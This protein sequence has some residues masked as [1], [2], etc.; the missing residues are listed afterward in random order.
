MYKLLF[1]LALCVGSLLTCEAKSSFILKNDLPI[2]R[3]NE[4]FVF[5]RGEFEH[6]FGAGKAGEVPLLVTQGKLINTQTDDLNGDG[7]WDELAFTVDIKAGSS[8]KLYG[9]WI[10]EKKVPK[11]E[12]RT[13]V[14]LGEENKNGG[15]TEVTEADAPVGLAGFPTHYQS[16]G[17][18]WENDK[19]AFRIYF[20]CRNTKDLFG[21]LIPDLIL[22]KAGSPTEPTYHELAPWGM[23]ILHCGSSL[24]AGSLA[25]VEG[26]SLYRLGSTPG[27]HYK[28]I[29]EGPV[30]TIFELTYKGWEVNGN[31]YEATERITLWIGKYWFQS[32]VRIHD[33]IGEKQVATG[34]TTTKLDRDPLQFQANSDYTAILTHGKQSLNNDILA[35]A[36]LAPTKEVRK[37]SRT[38]NT[39]FYKL[40]YQTVPAKSFSQVIS[41]TYYLSQKIKTESP[42][43]H[44]FFAMWGLEN[45]KWNEV[46][47]VKK[48]IREE[49]EKL[50]HPVTIEQGKQENVFKKSV[51]KK[52]METAAMWQ[53]AH[54]NHDL[55]DW[56]NGAFFAGMMAT[57]E[58]TGSKKIYQ[59]MLDMGKANGWKP[60]KLWYH[61]D[62]YAICQTYIDLY[63]LEK[64][65][66]MIQP[67]IDSVN[68]M[69]DTPY[70]ING[71]RKNFWWWCDALF[72]APP[73]LVKLGMTLGDK[74]YLE[75]NDKLFHETVDLLWNKEENLFARDLRFVWGYPEKD[76]KENNG[77]KVFWSRGN[78]WVM[79]GL[80]R[81]LTEL[82]AN[83]PNR[84]FYLDIFK[85]MAK[86]IASLQQADGLWRVSLL[87][88][89]SYPGGEASGSGFY[90]Y[91]LAWG[92]N[93]GILEREIYL[94]VVEKAWTGLNSLLTPEGYVGW[95]QPVGADPQKNYSSA[96]WE[97]YGTG[98]FLLAGSEVIKLNENFTR[99]SLALIPAPQNY[100]LAD[101][102][103]FRFSSICLEKNSIDSIPVSPIINSARIF[104]PGLKVD[105]ARKT[106]G[107]DQLTLIFAF[108]KSVVHTEGY[109]LKSEKKKVII[110]ASTKK[111]LFYGFQTL[112]QL[113][114][115][116]GS[117]YSVPEISIDDYPAF[118]IRGFMH[119][120]GRNF[121]TIES[122]KHQMDIWAFYKINVFHWHLTDNPAWRIE[123]KAY[124]QLNDPQF[125]QQGR[126]AG[127]FY[128]YDEI[129]DLIKYAGD[130]NI[131]VIP[132]IDVPGHSAYFGKTFGF[133][134][135]TPPGMDVLEKCL[136]EFFS[137]IK[138]ED[139]PYFHLGS[140]EVHINNVS[141]FIARMENIVL[142]HNRTPIVW[143]PGLPA[144]T[145]TIQQLWQEST[146]VSLK[147]NSQKQP[148]SL[149]IDATMGYVNNFDP[150]ILYRRIFL[151]PPCNRSEGDKTALGGILC[152]WPDV[153]VDDKNNI[154][155]HNPVYPSLLAFA[156]RYWNGGKIEDIAAAENSPEI[157]TPA[158]FALHDFERRTVKHRSGFLKEEAFPWYANSDIC[159][160]ISEYADTLKWHKCFGGS[161]DLETFLSSGKLPKKDTATVY[162]TTNIFSDRAQMVPC[163]IGFEAP[164]RSNRR[165]AGIPEQGKWDGNGGN[166]WINGKAV[167]PPV[168]EAPGK[169]R[170]LF[171]TWSR[172]EAEI[173]FTDEEFY[174]CRKP[175]E[176]SLNKGWNKVL[177]KVPK[178]FPDQNWTFTFVP[179]EKAGGKYTEAKNLRFSLLVI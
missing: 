162:A 107:K 124:P 49:A 2:D 60:G 164:H 112:L 108:D 177:I 129:R 88:P 103:P 152:C 175:V 48:Y 42:S 51:I 63:R 74:R 87:D 12:K 153:R 174:W 32:E 65:Q 45:S 123:C 122:L 33:F 30:R 101:T 54:P 113:I 171:A 38:A 83:Y 11:F 102:K 84:G 66:K 89:D 28:K 167:T 127:K 44:Y 114:R 133:K 105:I 82:P 13:Q 168:W 17:I 143:N 72:M 21:K 139:C 75:F 62:D 76:L 29:T 176:I 37:I 20:D 138:A 172:P 56:T 166:I 24:G 121:Q 94:P 79:G 96:S 140:D 111:G 106:L 157:N 134:M 78:G 23:D 135:E 40:G 43:V 141:E 39:D 50:S 27:Y 158:W 55:W 5:S 25:L 1:V 145:A 178:S 7:K 52:R 97:V 61:A 91:A 16:E 3:T 71:I 31:K 95:V 146:I 47:S 159:W 144:S 18:G 92:I 64:D 77:Q 67:T 34:I 26:D 118:A 69:M 6:R 161:V 68:K 81:I 119:D 93:H 128:T 70:A 117:E 86:R 59:A 142:K 120:V 154:F 10:N 41:E 156:E 90:C 125:Q 179:L 147:E 35:M 110:S 98:A 131:T 73:T 22:K 14:Y 99:G 19:M 160:N 85:K 115:K 155:R 169:Y 173:P 170:F 15:F 36:V 53:L 165:S 4:P 8:L 137:E 109:R 150:L 116:E 130:R 151:R 132:E 163:W 100:E 80:A 148:V 126:D 57:Y 136:N 58:T 9:V 46:D 149:V 104:F